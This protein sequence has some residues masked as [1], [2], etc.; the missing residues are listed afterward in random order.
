MWFLLFVVVCLILVIL[1][2]KEDHDHPETASGFEIRVHLRN[3]LSRE[4]AAQMAQ[5][6]IDHIHETFN[7][8]DSIWYCEYDVPEEQPK[9]P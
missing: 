2:N 8:D 6:L 9:W 4:Q 1:T 3:D 7:E 5:A